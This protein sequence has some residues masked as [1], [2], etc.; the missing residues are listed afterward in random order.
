MG[1]RPALTS[2]PHLDGPQ[3][4]HILLVRQELLHLDEGLLALHREL[5]P[6]LGPGQDRS[7]QNNIIEIS[8][9]SYLGCQ[10]LR[11]SRFN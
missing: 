8:F 2:L 3:S 9:F 11:K 4:Q 10:C 6:G 5:A 7:K 1:P